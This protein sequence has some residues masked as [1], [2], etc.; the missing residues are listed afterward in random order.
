MSDRRPPI[1]R[2]YWV[3]P[4]LMAGAYPGAVSRQEAREK[5]VAL[6]GAGVSQ[7]L[8]LTEARDGL[9][10][11]AELI[12]EVAPGAEVVHRTLPV[13]DLS[14]PSVEVVNQALDLIDEETARGGV[15]YVHCWGGIGRT[16]SIIGCWLARELG[17]DAALVRLQELRAVSSD[18]DRRSPETQAQCAL[19]RGWPI[20]T[21]LVAE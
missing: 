7:F 3:T 17:G 13:R 6:V 18:A 2:S 10:S 12:T 5:M 21:P 16:G 14:V 19:V 9:A 8:D 4:H 1:A 15:T 11:Y 20:R